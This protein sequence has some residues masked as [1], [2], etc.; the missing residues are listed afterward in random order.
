MSFGGSIVLMFGVFAVLVVAIGVF[1]FLAAKR[2]RE[3]FTALA[4]SRG[5]TYSERDDRWTEAFEGHPFG[6]GHSRRADNVLTGQYDSRA[7]VAFDYV[8]YTTES[9]TDA[10]GN[11][12]TRE[13]SH[14]F[15][16]VAV[17]TG[18]AFPELEVAPEGFFSRV[19][20]RLTDTD[21][22]LESEDF[23]RAFRVTCPDR[24]FASDILHPRMMEQLLRSPDAAFRFTGTHVLTATNGQAD[25]SQVEANLAFLDAVI[26][27]VPEFVWR[28]ARNG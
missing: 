4:A 5:W 12:T 23:N 22:E 2:R 17:D 18:V 24:K 3:A 14:T 15:A 1:G 16:V 6:R 21:I 26:D 20:G 8:Y 9:S 19:V 13:V 7:F 11:H 25:L 28:D 27:Q 10:N